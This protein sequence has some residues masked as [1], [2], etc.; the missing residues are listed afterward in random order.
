[1][2]RFVICAAIVACLLVSVPPV[3]QLIDAAQADVRG[4]TANRS[5][6]EVTA[7]QAVQNPFENVHRHS[8]TQEVKQ[9][10]RRAEYLRLAQ[11]HARLMNDQEL[12]EAIH[13]L[14]QTITQLQRQRELDAVTQL[15]QEIIDKHPDS[16]AAKRAAAAKQALEIDS[17]TAQFFEQL[18]GEAPFFDPN[19]DPGDPVPESQESPTLKHKRDK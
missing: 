15:L 7:D 8:R 19:G 13:D 2:K 17:E 10:G 12:T 14:E 5:Q 11:Q 9:T 1:M 6:E 4:Y 3:L 16:E 18:D